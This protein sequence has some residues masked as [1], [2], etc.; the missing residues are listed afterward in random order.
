MW[1]TKFHTIH[2]QVTIL[3]P[4][5]L[6]FSVANK[7]RE[8]SR[9]QFSRHSPNFIDPLFLHVCKLGSL[10]SFPNSWIMSQ[11]QRICLPSLC[12]NLVSHYVHEK[13]TFLVFSA[14]ASGSTTVLSTINSRVSI[15]S[16]QAFIH[17][18]DIE[19]T[20]TIITNVISYT[21]PF[22]II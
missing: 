12:C 3:C 16:I 17:W 18:N 13:W 8:D 4:Q 2:R 14:L 22:T 10:L 7:G 5:S 6:H 9:L 21:C 15:Y 20:T 1:E 19:T 11:S